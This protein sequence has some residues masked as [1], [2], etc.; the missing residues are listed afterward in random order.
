M[1]R[2][3]L[4]DLDGT[5]A[6]SIELIL[7]SARHAFIGFSG[8][9][10]TDVDWRAG[11]GR[12]LQAVLR[13]WADG[14][15]PEAQRLLTR[16]REFQ[17][18]HHDRLLRSY[19][20]M[21]EALQALSDEGFQLGIVTSKSD[22]LAQRAVD[23]LGMK[24]L[25]P[26]LVG[27]DTC[28]NHK[29]HPEPVERALA[30]MNMASSEAVYVGDSPHDILSGVAADVGTLGVTWGAFAR[31]ELEA[32]GADVVIDTVSELPAAVQRIFASRKRFQ[33]F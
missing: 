9:A 6:D 7:S 16:Y 26:V 5:V 17:L 21:T 19:P 2:A 27:C 28:V 25:F 15:E 32:S 22:W 14:D 33:T 11:I 12:P 4:F 1:P 10:P 18:E 23:F 24:E 20:G 8:K 30:L 3:V 31:A 13:E 29:P